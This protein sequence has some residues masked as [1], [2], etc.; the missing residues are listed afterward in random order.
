MVQLSSAREVQAALSAAERVDVLAYTL[1]RGPVLHGLEA[2]ARRGAHVRVRL[3]GVPYGDSSGSFAR[4]NRRIVDELTRAGIDAQLARVGPRA[5]DEAPVHAKAIVADD[6]LFLDDRNWGDNDF[7]V[8]DRDPAAARAVLDAMD[9]DAHAGGCPSFAIEKRD[10][11]AREA[12]LLQSAKPGDR[13]IV[14]SESFGYDNPVYAALDALGK[15]G[16]S[17]RLLVSSREAASNS[18]ERKAL[19]RLVRDGVAVRLCRDSE[20]FALA[21]ERAWLGSANASPAFGT[22]DMIDW[23]LCTDDPATVAAARAAVEARW[24]SAKPL[25][26]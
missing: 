25:K 22:P 20:K 3:E 16:A 13:V 18:R 2:A 11:L 17:P 5:A 4:E 7:V 8:C 6:R 23:G 9:G 15:S 19:E 1:R 21:G 26:T 10:A 24:N 12:D 14:E